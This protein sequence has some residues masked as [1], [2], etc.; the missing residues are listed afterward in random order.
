MECGSSGQYLRSSCGK[1]K[2]RRI[3]SPALRNLTSWLNEILKWNLIDQILVIAETMIKKRKKNNNSV[4]CFY[5][6]NFF[7]LTN[8]IGLE[9]WV[10]WDNWT[11]KRTLN[12]SLFEKL[13][14]T[15]FLYFFKSQMYAVPLVVIFPLYVYSR[16]TSLW[17]PLF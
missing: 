7:V 2:D 17:D 16:A 14:Y 4:F 5:F 8:H 12:F 15:L 6:K 1:L 10:N 3:E 13:C 9:I 11:H